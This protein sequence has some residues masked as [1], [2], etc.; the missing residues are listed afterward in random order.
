MADQ[1]RFLKMSNAQLKGHI[2][3]DI[4]TL[5]GYIGAFVLDSD[6]QRLYTIVKGATDNTGKIVSVDQGLHFVNAITD[7]PKSITPDIIGEFYYV[8]TSNILCVASYT[9]TDGTGWVQI[10]AQQDSIAL[11]ELTSETAADGTTATITIGGIL[12]KLNEDGYDEE[13]DHQPSQQVTSTEITIKTEGGI[14]VTKDE[15]DALVLSAASLDAM[16]YKGTVDFT[17]T[18]LPT[19][20]ITLGD[21]YYVSADVNATTWNGIK[22]NYTITSEITSLTKGDL[23]IAN[24]SN[25]WDYVPSGDETIPEYSVQISGQNFTFKKDDTGIGTIKFNNTTDSN[26]HL[27]AIAAGTTQTITAKMYWEELSLGTSGS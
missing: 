11:K 22:N 19:T 12:G 9:A 14:N 17:S 1:V 8:A 2:E 13:E 4:Q 27:E 10:N 7:L 24:S 20:N 3:E 5:H 25:G 26:I 21:T 15:N 23:F 16:T 18:S 6:T